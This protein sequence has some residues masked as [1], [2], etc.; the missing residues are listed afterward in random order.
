MSLAERFRAR[1]PRRIALVL[2]SAVGD[3]VHGMPVAASLRRAWPEAELDW[4]IQPGPRELVAPHPDV[5]EFLVLDRGRGLRGFVDFF[6]RHRGRP[7]DL[8][9]DLQVYLKAGLVTAALR[10]PVKL[11]FDRA[12]ARDLNGLFT[13]HRIPPHPPQHVQEQYFEFLAHLGVPAIRRWDFAFTEEERAAR[14]AFFARLER[15]AL[16]VVLRT[17]RPGKDWPA[18]RYA[19]VLEVAEAD[20]GLRPVFVGGA[21]AGEREAARQV[22]RATRADPVDALAWDL[23]RLAWLL[24]GSALLLSPDTGPLHVAVA[25]DT[26]VVGLYGYTDPKR[27]GPYR[28]F[29]DLVVDRYTRPGETTP[30]AEF[31]PGNMERITVEEV[32]EKVELAVRRH[33]RPGPARTRGRGGAPSEER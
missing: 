2:L 17:T 22:A 8:V 11:G 15:P 13:T 19:H 24:D 3:V 29:G 12:R 6:R 31:R 7:Y 10:A 32:L 27:V 14:D 5:S 16:A 1:P 26:P 9:V 25:L 33:V 18:E 28:R 30:S 20:L 21:S 23:R 4:V